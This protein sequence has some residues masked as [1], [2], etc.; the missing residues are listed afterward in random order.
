[1]S[2][3]VNEPVSEQYADYFE[4]FPEEDG[5]DHDDDPE[6]VVDDVGNPEY[7]RVVALMTMGWRGERQASPWRTAVFI[8]LRRPANDAGSTLTDADKAFLD[9]IAD[10]VVGRIAT[11][12]AHGKSKCKT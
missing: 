8:A 4:Q 2:T 7:A 11:D 5:H 9:F 12:L 6:E 10:G 3:Q 1:M